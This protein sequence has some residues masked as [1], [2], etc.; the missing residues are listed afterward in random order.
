M[1]NKRERTMNIK[2][3]ILTNAA[4]LCAVNSANALT[5]YD[6]NISALNINMLTDTFMAY[7]NYGEK[8]SDLFGKHDMYGTM[9][10]LDEYGD[11]GSTLTTSG[12]EY[13]SNDG[14]IN[15]M[16][17]NANHINSDIH[18]GNNISTR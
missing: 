5:V 9:D 6:N 12:Y 16:W 2:T 13:T 8:M 14:F 17:I 1:L 18:Y 3:I 4:L 10:R 11:D 7:T 15:D